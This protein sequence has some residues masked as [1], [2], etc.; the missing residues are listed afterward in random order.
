MTN[1]RVIKLPDEF[2]EN[3]C[4]RKLLFLLKLYLAGDSELT[5]EDV[6]GE[7]TTAYKNKQIIK[8]QFE[9]FKSWSN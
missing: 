1:E 2:Y 9:A 5:K 7:I 8:K 4:S 6:E 3:D